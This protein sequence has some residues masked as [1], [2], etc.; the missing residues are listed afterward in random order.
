MEGESIYEQPFIEEHAD[1]FGRLMA[2][3]RVVLRGPFTSSA[4]TLPLSVGMSLVKAVDE[5]GLAPG[6]RPIPR[7]STRCWRRSCIPFRSSPRTRRGQT[8]RRCHRVTV[9][10]ARS[11]CRPVPRRSEG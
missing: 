8:S 11:Y 9:V 6:S 10:F 7:S 3:H 5:A 1:H 4:K 2:E